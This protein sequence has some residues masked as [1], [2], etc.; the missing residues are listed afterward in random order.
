MGRWKRCGVIVVLFSTDHDPRHVHVFED[1]KRLRYFMRNPRFRGIKP[2]Y[3]KY[4]FEIA[5]Q[6]GRRVSKYHLPFAVF[7]NKKIG[8]DN[9]VVSI[10]ID[11]ELG[12]QGAVLTLEDGSQ[13]DFPADFVL[14]YC[15]PTYDWAPINQLKKSLKDK[16]NGSRISVRTL[17]DALNTSPSQVV[18]LL[19]GSK[20][21][22][23]LVQLFHVA[24]LVGYHIEFH[25]KKKAA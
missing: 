21:S 20:V 22:K 9:R 23:Q 25:L 13:C 19:K 10:S 17:A 4:A 11:R 15:D 5:L 3:R 6:E 12:G 14:Y 24:E 2:N 18:R 7:R 1:G 16:L 8:T